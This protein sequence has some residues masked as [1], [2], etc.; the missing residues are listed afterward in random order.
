MRLTTPKRRREKSKLVWWHCKLLRNCSYCTIIRG[1]AICVNDCSHITALFF[2]I[3]RFVKVS[4]NLS[5]KSTLTNKV[6]GQDSV[7]SWF[8][9]PNG[10]SSFALET[11]AIFRGR[12]KI[13]LETFRYTVSVCGSIHVAVSTGKLPLTREKQV[14]YQV[15]RL[16]HYHIW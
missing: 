9:L 5:K 4:V 3:N 6:W 14:G 11:N 16:R 7:T 2:S 1:P 15:E 12:P 13:T 10:M 8:Y